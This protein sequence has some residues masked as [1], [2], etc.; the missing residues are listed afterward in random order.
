MTLAE[1]GTYLGRDET[2]VY[3]WLRKG[4]FVPGVMKHADNPT[5]YRIRQDELWAWMEDKRSWHLWEPAAL[6]D[7]AARQHFAVLRAE[8]VTSKEAAAVLCIEPE[9]V[10]RAVQRGQLAGAHLDNGRTWINR[11]ELEAYRIRNDDNLIAQLA[12]LRSEVTWL[13]QQLERG[14]YLA[15]GYP[16]RARY[17]TEGANR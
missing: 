8:W 7:L 16:T 2:S 4:S 11:R 14:G 9:A 17:A 1:V 5:P 6:T 15:V 13:R 3:E 10:Q 12:A